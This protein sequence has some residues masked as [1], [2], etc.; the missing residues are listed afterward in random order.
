[1][2]WH[3]GNTLRTVNHA[4]IKGFQQKNDIHTGDDDHLTCQEGEYHT[5]LTILFTSEILAQK[6]LPK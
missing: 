6:N 4:S 5:T 2:D 1:M 3:L